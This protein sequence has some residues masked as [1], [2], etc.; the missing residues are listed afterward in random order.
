MNWRAWTLWTAGWVL[1]YVALDRWLRR[2][3]H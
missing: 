3:W 2:R 1:A